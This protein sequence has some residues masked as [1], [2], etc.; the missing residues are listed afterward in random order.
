MDMQA[1]INGKS[2][3]GRN[4]VAANRPEVTSRKTKS[5]LTNGTKLLPGI[6]GRSP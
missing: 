3:L 2:S 6:D 1:E 4:P 5:A